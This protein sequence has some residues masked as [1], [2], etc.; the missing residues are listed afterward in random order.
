MIENFFLSV[1]DSS[2]ITQLVSWLMLRIPT[3][4]FPKNLLTALSQK[5]ATTLAEEM[6]LICAKS[7]K[8]PEKSVHLIH[9][10]PPATTR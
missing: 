5:T 2:H 8:T 7:H 4:K 6:V 10:E 1:L 9:F 3:S